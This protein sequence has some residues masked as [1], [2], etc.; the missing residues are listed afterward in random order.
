MAVAAAAP[1]A[2]ASPV[3]VP[4]VSS[5]QRCSQRSGGG[6][7]GGRNRYYYKIVLALRGEGCSWQRCELNITN[8]RIGTRDLDWSVSGNTIYL[9]DVGQLSGTIVVTGTVDCPHK[10]NFT[11]NI[12]TWGFSDDCRNFDGC[13]IR[14]GR[15][16]EG[17]D[18]AVEST[19]NQTAPVEQAE[20]AAQEPTFVET[21]AEAPMVNAQAPVVEPEAVVDSPVA[22]GYTTPAHANR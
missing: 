3:C 7:G 4:T 13:G 1:K 16:I 21:P 8:I 2:A 6:P 14:G 22:T 5:R 19:A 15:S 12:S 11:L 10:T 9:C 17:T 20:A 18:P